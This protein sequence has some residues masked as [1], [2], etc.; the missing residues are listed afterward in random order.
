MPTFCAVPGC[1]RRGGFSFP[2]DQ[3]L[4]KQWCVAIRRAT[5]KGDLWTP[6]KRAV[7]CDYHFE[8]KD[9]IT[10]S[11]VD[12]GQRMKRHL[13]H[14][15]VPTVFDFSR[16]G[17]ES[18][19]S[20]RYERA[21]KRGHPPGSSQSLPPDGDLTNNADSSCQGLHD[22]HDSDAPNVLNAEAP[23]LQEDSSEPWQFSLEDTDVMMEVEIQEDDDMRVEQHSDHAEELEDSTQDEGESTLVI[24][25]FSIEFFKNNSRMVKFYTS[26]C[27]YKHFKFF[28]HCLGPA[29]GHLTY[30]SKSL[31][32]EDELFLTLIKL[33]LNKEDEELAFF[34]GVTKQVVGRIF[35]TWLNF[36][37]FQ[38]HELNLWLPR[39][40]IDDFMPEDFRKK[41]PNTRVII[42]ATEIP[43]ERPGCTKAQAA[44]WSSYK[45]KNTLKVLVGISP[46]GAVTFVSDVFGGSASDRQIVERCSLATTDCF[47]Q[48]DSI[49]ADK[50]FVVQDLFS[51]RGVAINRPTLLKGI[52]QLPPDAV[53][54]DQKVSS[55]RVHVER[56]IGA[57]KIFKILEQRLSHHYL[58][59]GGRILFVCLV[60]QNF[61]P[62]IVD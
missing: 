33:R 19:E 2:S 32:P 26:F 4:R 5:Q 37:S 28:F 25:S 14:G 1:N 41:F 59:Y 60:I 43:I 7:V 3:G 13:S 34:F 27:D 29:S 15:A 50:G 38:L 62:C 24:G 9:I 8:A 10:Q 57:A 39:S 35:H 51:H 56:V 11:R 48:G 18:A 52:N 20:E 23:P 47:E 21:R 42:D 49:M 44:T 61:K 45:N 53:S 31:K 55:K 12:T 46:K 58:K 16:K 17:A 36:L 30:K 54:S 22:I 40:V 6:N